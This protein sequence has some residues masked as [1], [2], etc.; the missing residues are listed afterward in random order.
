MDLHGLFRQEYFATSEGSYRL[1][2]RGHREK[3]EV[4]KIFA[5]ADLK[6]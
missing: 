2:H 5:A 3:L 6:T 1:E 4:L